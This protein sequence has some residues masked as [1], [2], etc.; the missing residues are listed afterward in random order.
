MGKGKDRDYKPRNCKA[1]AGLYPLF[2][3]LEIPFRKPGACGS[4]GL[5]LPCTAGCRNL[6]LAG[7]SAREPS[8]RCRETPQ[9]LRWFPSRALLE[10]DAR[11]GAAGRSKPQLPVL[12]V[13]Q[14]AGFGGE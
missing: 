10:E 9:G 12:A 6:G 4:V 14:T 1:G 13:Q 3:G 2:P 8:G 7:S 5:C 11:S